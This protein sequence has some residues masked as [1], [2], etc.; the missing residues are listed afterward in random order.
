MRWRLFQSSVRRQS[1]A[2]ACLARP[3]QLLPCTAGSVPSWSYSSTPSSPNSNMASP[4]VGASSNT[5]VDP[6]KQARY[7]LQLG[8]GI[9]DRTAASSSFNAVRRGFMLL[10][11]Q[12]NAADIICKSIT[13]LSTIKGHDL[14]D[15]AHEMPPNRS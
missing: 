10:D 14:H 2:S 11:M 4:S 12:N 3:C 6:Q 7:T 13:S 9:K 5:F 8:Q 15:L 1:P